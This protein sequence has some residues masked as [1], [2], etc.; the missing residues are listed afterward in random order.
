MSYDIWDWDGKD[1]VNSSIYR[2]RDLLKGLEGLGYNTLKVFPMLEYMDKRSRFE[3][4]INS[5]F[6][7]LKEVK[8][9]NILYHMKREQILRELPVTETVN[10][11]K[12]FYTQDN[13]ELIQKFVDF[14]GWNSMMF[15][16]NNFYFPAM[17]GE[18][19]GCTESSVAL[20]NAVIRAL[21]LR[22]EKEAE[23]D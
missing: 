3:N 19:H 15:S 13:P 23:W 9:D 11:E 18:Q 20:S 10:N 22:K 14:A 16:T 2:M 5:A 8:E 6:E 12:F 4:S 7:T 21:H 1:T 17:N